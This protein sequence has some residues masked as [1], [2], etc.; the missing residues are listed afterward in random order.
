MKLKLKLLTL[1]TTAFINMVNVDLLAFVC[2]GWM[3]VELMQEQ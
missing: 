3:H 1:K 2:F